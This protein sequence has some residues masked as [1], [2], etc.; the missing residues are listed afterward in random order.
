MEPHQ[1]QCRFDFAPP[2]PP[3]PDGQT[4]DPALDGPRLKGQTLDVFNLMRDGQWRTL[5]QIAYATG[6]P[7]AS[8]SARLRDLRKPKYGGH[9]VERRRLGDPTRGIWEY[10]VIV[11]G[12]AV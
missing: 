7:E 12:G 10:R 4:F 5:A 9:T 8:L 1:D 11:K 3:T 2:L 6:H